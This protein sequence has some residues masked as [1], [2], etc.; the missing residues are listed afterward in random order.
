MGIV[1]MNGFTRVVDCADM[2]QHEPQLALACE[3]HMCEQL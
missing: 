1:Q 3:A 2:T